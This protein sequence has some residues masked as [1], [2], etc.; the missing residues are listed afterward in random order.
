MTLVTAEKDKYPEFDILALAA[1]VFY[2]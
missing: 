1:K 2:D